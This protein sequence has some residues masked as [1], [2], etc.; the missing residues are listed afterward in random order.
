MFCDSQNTSLKELYL[1]ENEI[2]DV[3]ATG[4]GAGLAYVVFLSPRMNVPSFITPPDF[5]VGYWAILFEISCFS[6]RMQFEQ[7][8]ASADA[9]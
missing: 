4:L 3:G 1:F 6:H 5:L 7:D 8:V 2:G 9:R